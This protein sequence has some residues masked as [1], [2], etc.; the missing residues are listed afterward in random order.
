MIISMKVFIIF[1]L[2]FSLITST[3]YAQSRSGLSS[4]AQPNIELNPSYPQ[5]NEEV[6]ATISNFS[7]LEYGSFI[8]WEIDGE[9]IPSGNNL[10]N[11][12]FTS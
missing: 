3:A 2:S 9:I 10:Q 6:S 7:N 5:P 12:T 8:Q 4:G 1:I 11:I